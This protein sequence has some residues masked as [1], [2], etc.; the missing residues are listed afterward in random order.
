M[1]PAPTPVG[2]SSFAIAC[3]PNGCDA[4][5]ETPDVFRIGGDAMTNLVAGD[6]VLAAEVHQ[7]SNASSD[8]VFGAAVTLVR[9][10]AG[11]T[12]LRINMTNSTPCVSWDGEFLTLQHA[13]VFSG[14][15]AW[16][17]VPGSIKSPYCITNPVSSRFYR[18]RN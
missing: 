3:P 7:Q 5:F 4:T 18:L 13:S 1:E 8:V 14:S 10:T 16:S 11:E 6:N 12:K 9:A 15:N 17:D 2:Y